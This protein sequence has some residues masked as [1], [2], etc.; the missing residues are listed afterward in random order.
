MTCLEEFLPDAHSGGYLPRLKWMEINAMYIRTFF[1]FS[2]FFFH[3]SLFF[4]LGTLLFVSKIL[5]TVQ[6]S[7]EEVESALLAG[8]C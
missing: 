6:E 3:F 8:S 4:F 5:K 7:S 1:S 2:F